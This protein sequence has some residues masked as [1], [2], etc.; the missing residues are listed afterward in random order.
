MAHGYK[1]L[2]SCGGP[3]RA[4]ADFALLLES[5]SRPASTLSR[6]WPS[7]M[8]QQHRAL[9]YSVWA[10]PWGDLPVVY[11]ALALWHL[12]YPDQALKRSHDALTLAQELSHPFSLAYALHFAGM[13]PQ[14]RRESAGSPG[15]GRGN[16]T[17]CTEQGFSYWLAYGTILWGWALAEQGQREEGI[18]QMRQG[19]AALGPQGQS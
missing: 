12:G 10:R 4:G 8:P 7:T 18:A 14:L 16:D 1:T 9:A 11:V 3:L 15:A 17:L 6:A 2:P 19:L 5:L 13:L